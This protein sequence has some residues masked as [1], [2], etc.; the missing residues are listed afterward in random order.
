MKCYSCIYYYSEAATIE[1]PFEGEHCLQDMWVQPL[2]NVPTTCLH[3]KVK[4]IKNKEETL[5]SALKK[6]AQNPKAIKYINEPY[7]II[8]R[9]INNKQKDKNE[10]SRINN[11][12]INKYL[13][14]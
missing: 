6:L 7:S 5:K 3:Y 12:K 4:I 8:L 13:Q 9:N 2:V 14:K 10:I 1:F 11:K